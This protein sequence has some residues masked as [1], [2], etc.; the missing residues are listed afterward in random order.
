MLAHELPDIHFRLHLVHLYS[1]KQRFLPWYGVLPMFFLR[2]W[3]MIKP[4]K[5]YER[6]PLRRFSFIVITMIVLIYE[7][8][9]HDADSKYGVKT[10]RFA[11]VEVWITRKTISVFTIP[12]KIQLKSACTAKIRSTKASDDVFRIQWKQFHST[13]S[14]WPR[15]RRNNK[16]A[17][18]SVYLQMGNPLSN[19]LYGSTRD[20]NTP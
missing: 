19:G 6:K 5:L 14:C 8:A 11:Y 18:I 9:W 12:L 1:P 16:F 3:K 4:T 2:A 7:N 17:F 15:I 10:K 20:T 13:T